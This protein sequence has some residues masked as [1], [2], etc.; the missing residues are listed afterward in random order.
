MTFVEKINAPICLSTMGLGGFPSSHPHYTGMIGMH[1]TKTSN[2]AATECDLLIAI[3]ARF[4]DRVIS[5]VTK[6]APNAKILH[7][8][9]DP[10]EINKNVIVYTSI[11]GDLKEILQRLNVLMDKKTNTEWMNHILQ[12]KETYPLK[13][14][15]DD[16]LKPQYIL[17]RISEITKG[18]A[19]ITTEVGQHQMWACQYIKYEKPRSFLTSG[20][21]GTMGYGLGAS[22][23]AKIACPDKV[24]INIAGD[25][26]FRM[27]NIEIAT[28][29]EYDVPVIV[30]IMNNHTLGMVRQWQTFFYDKRFSHTTLDKTTDFVKLAEAYKAVAFSITKKEEV[31]D[32]IM[33][34]IALKK[35]VIIN[36][37]IDCDEKVFPMVPPGAGID[38]L[39]MD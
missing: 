24:V 21:L 35:P 34:A 1:G 18:E 39:L 38:E 7:I 32:I 2:M 6:F 16:S 13:Y 19:I 27:N 15:N 9:I 17:E 28:A 10:A 22:I 30:V 37:E 36:C 12:M 33:K 4:S 14:E 20:G 23:G 8:D 3:G 31:D 11:V 5:N 25:G 26:C 29:V